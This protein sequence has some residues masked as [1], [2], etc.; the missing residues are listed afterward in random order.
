MILFILKIPDFSPRKKSFEIKK[1]Y[2]TKIIKLGLSSNIEMPQLG[3][4]RA[5]KIPAR[6]QHYQ[7]VTE[8]RTYVVNTP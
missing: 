4:A 3:S 5:V 8:M 2:I 6:A 7:I 1:L